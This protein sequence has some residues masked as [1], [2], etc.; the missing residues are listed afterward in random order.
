MVHLNPLCF[1]FKVKDVQ[2]YGSIVTRVSEK[3]SIVEKVN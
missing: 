1:A 2:F 3:N